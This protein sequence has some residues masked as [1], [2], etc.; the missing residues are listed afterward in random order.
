MFGTVPLFT[1]GRYPADAITLA[2]LLEAS[3]SEAE[4]FELMER[5]PP[6][7]INV[8]RA[9]GKRLQEVQDR[10]REVSTQPGRTARCPGRPA[11]CSSSRA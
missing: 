9:I 4:L 1:D 10:L 3:W 11:A 2:E 6:I 7:A 8:I 5:Y